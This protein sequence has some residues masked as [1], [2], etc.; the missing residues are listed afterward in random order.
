M[1]TLTPEGFL[2]MMPFLGRRVFMKRFNLFIQEK[3]TAAGRF[4]ESKPGHVDQM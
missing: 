3:T 4:T 1:A 2:G